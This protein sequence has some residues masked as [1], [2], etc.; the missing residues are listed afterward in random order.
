M[1]TRTALAASA[2]PADFIWRCGGIFAHRAAR[3]YVTAACLS[4]SGQDC[5]DAE[6]YKTAFPR[7][8]YEL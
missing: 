8:I 7:T 6:G 3:E 1:G 4:F 2:L 5:H